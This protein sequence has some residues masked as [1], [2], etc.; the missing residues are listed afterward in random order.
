MDMIEYVNVE[1]V[2]GD[3]NPSIM[4]NPKTPAQTPILAMA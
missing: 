2:G 4:N 3:D 1:D